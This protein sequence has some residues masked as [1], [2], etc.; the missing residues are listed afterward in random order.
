MFPAKQSPSTHC[1]KPPETTQAGLLA[2]KVRCL[3]FRGPQLSFVVPM[4]SC[5]R[6][7]SAAGAFLQHF[8]LMNE[9]LAV[10]TKF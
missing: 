5:V 7:P 10:Y 8:S 4:D 9:V 2:T 6:V 3:R 1:H